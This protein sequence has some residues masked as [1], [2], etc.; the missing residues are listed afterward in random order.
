MT[1]SDPVPAASRVAMLVANRRIARR[2]LIAIYPESTNN[3]T[4]E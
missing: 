2:M 3:Q 1:T 4:T